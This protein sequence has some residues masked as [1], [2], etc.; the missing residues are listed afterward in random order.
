MRKREEEGMNAPVLAYPLDEME[1][2]SVFS[3]MTSGT[4]E[5]ELLERY[6]DLFI[7]KN[8]L[9]HFETDAISK[10]KLIAS[11]VL[12][13]ALFLEFVLHALYHLP[14]IYLLIAA[15]LVF[16]FIFFRRQNLKR[17]LVREVVLRPDDLLD[18]I[19][20]SQ[21][22]GAKN[23]LVNRIFSSIPLA[24]AL[25]AVAALFMRPHMIY[26]KNDMGGYS[27]RYY[28]HSI[29]K[30][31]R[32]TVPETYNG[33]PVNEIRGSVFRN[34]RQL[35][36]VDLPSG[37]TEIRGNTFERCTHLLKIEIPYGVT[38]IGGSAFRDCSRLHT[39]ILPDTVTEI[40]SSAFR[41][42]DSLYRIHIPE[43]AYVNS[44]AFKDSPTVFE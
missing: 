2:Q 37:I 3:N 30:E 6:I 11:L 43:G 32:V 33:E 21:V 36:Y 27:L 13:A 31:D 34:M 14:N 40:G 12:A 35:E 4:S 41:D 23:A 10:R 39:V 20:I 38:R 5:Q 24:V 7:R 16:Y 18:N 15:E 42:C 22:S 29:I 25:I 26:E 44:R 17:Y 9:E 19:L 28:T 8:R 1:K